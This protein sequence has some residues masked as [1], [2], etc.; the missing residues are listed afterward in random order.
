MFEYLNIPSRIQ[1][2]LPINRPKLIITTCDICILIIIQ[3]LMMIL[4]IVFQVN[5][6]QYDGNF[7]GLKRFVVFV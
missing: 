7:C 2:H 5:S 4:W 3:K 1:H 6:L